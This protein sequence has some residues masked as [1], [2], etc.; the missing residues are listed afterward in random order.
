LTYNNKENR[1]IF[2]CRW[3]GYLHTPNIISANKNIQLG[4]VI[5]VF[6][7]TLNIKTNS[8]EL[9]V[10]TMGKVRSPINM[11]VFFS[12]DYNGQENCNAKG[13]KGILNYGCTIRKDSDTV[14]SI[15]GRIFLH[16]TNPKVFKNNLRKR[17][18]LAR[19]IKFENTNERILEILNKQ[20][21]SGC[22][23]RPDIMNTGLLSKFLKQIGK[24]VKTCRDEKK[25]TQ[26]V[27]RYL[28]QLCGRGPGFTPSGD[29]FISGY[30]VLFNYLATSLGL[31]K[32]NLPHKQIAH[33]TTWISSRL[34]AYYERCIIDEQ[35]QS[36]I[37]SLADGNF[38][39]YISSLVQ[40]SYRGHTSGIDIATGVTAALYTIIDRRIG[41]NL[42]HKLLAISLK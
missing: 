36:M 2:D 21:R 26:L 30:C 31:E 23:L 37:N 27:K 7:H 16:V 41:T 14:L 13:F 12:C 9:L 8:N 33:L 35:V 15:G 20:S 19:L 18:T 34:M 10:V 4:R 38:E 17:P 29:D 32:I 22:L 39:K 3:I 24:Y 40:I 6:D 42:L 25:F 11:N 1:N 5:S 28:L